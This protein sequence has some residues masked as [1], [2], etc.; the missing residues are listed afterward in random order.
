M[1]GIVELSPE[2][3]VVLGEGDQ[4]ELECKVGIENDTFPVLVIIIVVVVVIIFIMTIIRLV[5][6]TPDPPSP[7]P[8]IENSLGFLTPLDRFANI[9]DRDDINK[10]SVNQN[11]L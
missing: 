2:D 8:V 4:A 6:P 1:E 10:V 5:L 9:H 11:C 7:G 3:V